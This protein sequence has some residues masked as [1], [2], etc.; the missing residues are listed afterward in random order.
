[1]ALSAK[2]FRIFVSSTFED[3]KEERNALQERVFPRLRE[4]CAEYG[5]RFQAIDLRWGISD[6]SAL[7]QRSVD[8]CVEE[9]ERCQHTELKPTFIVLLG[10]R[11]GWRPLPYEIEA[12][13]FEEIKRHISRC[14]TRMLARWY[15]CD[16]NEV[17]PVFCLQPRTC[18]YV[19]KE[20]WERVE[21]RLRTLLQRAVE[22]LTLTD[23]EHVD[24][25]GSATGHEV[26]H[27]ALN[28]DPV[29]E[30]AFA[31]FRTIRGLPSHT[32]ARRY[33][34]LCSDGTLDR[35]AQGRLD[36]L[37]ARLEAH[38]PRSNVFSYNIRWK[39]EVP[40]G[41]RQL[42]D[43]Y[44]DQFCS[45]VYTSL[46]STII[47][48]IKR[49]GTVDHLDEELNDHR[50]FGESRVAFFT[51]RMS[52]LAAIGA[53]IDANPG[54]Q[55]LAMHGPA[56]SGK[57]ALMAEA[58]RHAAERYPEAVVAARFVGATAASTNVRSLLTFLCKEIARRFRDDASSVPDEYDALVKDF[59]QR[60]ARVSRHGSTTQ[61]RIRRFL[62]RAKTE[63]SGEGP[64]L[65]IFIDALD[66]LS[67]DYD[68]RH[69]TWLPTSLPDGV[70]LIVSTLPGE[71][72]TELEERPSAR[73]AELAPMPAREGAALLDR[74]LAA[75]HRT[76]QPY[77]R[78]EVLD[79]FA[80]CGRP[81]YLKLAFEEARRWH[82]F[83]PPGSLGT[84]IAGVLGDLFARLSRDHG[85]VLVSHGLGYL[86]A[87][88]YGLTEDELLDM[89]SRDRVVRKDF[90]AHAH[91]APPKR[92]LP[93][94]VWSRLYFDLEPYLTERSADGTSLM[95]FYHRQF[96][97]AVAARFLSEPDGRERRL[98]LAD[99]YE[100]QPLFTGGEPSQPL[101][102]VRQQEITSGLNRRKLTELPYQFSQAHAW[103]D[104]F[105]ILKDVSFF[106][107]AWEANQYDVEAYWTQVEGHTDRSVSQA[108]QS[109]LGAAE[110]TLEGWYVWRLL[111]EMGHLETAQLFSKN[112]VDIYRESDDDA[113]LAVSLAAQGIA[114]MESGELDRAVEV[115]AEEEQ[116]WQRLSHKSGLIYARLNRGLALAKKGHSE[117]AML[118]FKECERFYR[119]TGDTI[120]LQD[121]ILHQATSYYQCGEFDEAM[122]L[123]KE[124]ERFYR[125][126]GNAL[127]LQESL[128]GQAEV[129]FS[130][131][132]LDDAI[133]RFKQSEAICVEHSFKPGLHRALSGQASCL[134]LQGEFDEAMALY[135]ECEGLCREMNKI[136]GL[137]ESIIGQAK[138]FEGQDKLDQALVLYKNSEHICRNAGYLK[139]LQ[140]ALGGQAMIFSVMGN[141]NRALQLFREQERICR[142]IGNITLLAVSLGNHALL[143]SKGELREAAV[144]ARE[145]YVLAHEHNLHLLEI[146]IEKELGFLL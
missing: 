106:V 71:S 18:K 111:R 41:K 44:L 45:D 89:L 122:A 82:S 80:K 12:A 21:Q 22:G 98:A 121:S 99:Y 55:V 4:L 62:K 139:G 70:R 141:A 23:A 86:G 76:L 13:R 29:E 75:A 117:E 17:P 77:Q 7:D 90:V 96:S 50:T 69:L 51:G 10:Q 131:G 2:T 43:A 128:A 110:P 105:N 31:F 28:V 136:D 11:Y 65:V 25:F 87:A 134:V 54:H 108:Y 123:Y 1:M 81:L 140:A 107:K 142:E 145:A 37:K 115:F 119:E 49:I 73:L 85:D 102:K 6:E 132:Y 53:Y 126:T 113:K 14:D 74:W 24:F 27:G 101:T 5:F 144:L 15:R 59:Q 56:G 47:K 103:K 34:D 124:C 19:T 112:A 83:T 125:E 35:D 57:T 39:E 32:S 109:V 100:G 93:V 88:R 78:D 116:A 118:L 8:I 92:R 97:E 60:L 79:A 52:F 130:Q 63:Q 38:L 40:R 138:V 137:S 104:L 120:G 146:E 16:N 26:Y 95:T 20:E 58:A 30:H 91:H 127:R 66:Q 135:K 42:P 114:L 36:E 129:L 133:L 68:A 46:A 94:V 48:E 64:S 143:A 33:I 61:S 9:I 67:D 72:L 84:T 3:F